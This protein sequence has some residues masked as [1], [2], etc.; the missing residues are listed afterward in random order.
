[1]PNN[2]NA[3]FLILVVPA[4]AESLILSKEKSESEIGNLAIAAV[5]IKISRPLH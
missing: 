5:V 4:V 1:M 3:R 2:E